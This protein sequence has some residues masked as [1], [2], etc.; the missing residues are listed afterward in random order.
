MWHGHRR[1]TP[2]EPGFSAMSEIMPAMMRGRQAAGQPTRASTYQYAPRFLV[3]DE[4]LAAQGVDAV[5]Q[6][7]RRLLPADALP[8]WDL[9]VRGQASGHNE[10]IAEV[11]ARWIAANGAARL[12]YPHHS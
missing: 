7:V 3:C 2:W 12:P 4:S 1:G 9:I 6:T 5:A 8:G 10:Q 11:A